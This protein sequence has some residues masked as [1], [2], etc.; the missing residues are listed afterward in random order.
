MNTLTKVWV[1]WERGVRLSGPAHYLKDG[2]SAR[3]A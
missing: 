3:G 2:A 1:R